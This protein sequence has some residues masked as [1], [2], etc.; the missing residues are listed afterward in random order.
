VARIVGNRGY[1]L[2]PPEERNRYRG[3]RDFQLWWLVF[4][5]VVLGSYGFFLWF[6]LLRVW[7]KCLAIRR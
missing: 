4:V 6:D 3:W 1:L 5:A 7:G 2:L